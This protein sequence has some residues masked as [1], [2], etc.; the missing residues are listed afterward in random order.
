MAVC[1]P[2]GI[3]HLISSQRK[4]GKAG[5]EY[6]VMDLGL[7]DRP[8]E[9]FARD[10]VSWKPDVVCFSVLSK[11]AGEMGRLASFVKETRGETI[12][13]AGGPHATACSDDV[14][15]ESAVDYCVIGEGERTFAELMDSIAGHGNPEDVRGIVHRSKGA[16]LRT[17]ARSFIEDLD[18]LPGP[19]WEMI[20]LKR[21]SGKQSMNVVSAARVY[22]P[23]MTSR[24]C[25]YECIYCHGMFG[26]KH[27]VFSVERIIGE[28]RELNE[29]FGVGEF[30]VL[31]DAFNLD[32]ERSKRIFREI[33]ASGIKVK[34]SFPNGIRGD[35]VDE[36]MID[37]M[38]R[39]GTYMVTFGVES[40]SG[41]IQQMIRKN[42]DLDKVQKAISM[43]DSEGMLVRGFFM[44]GF[45]GE[46]VD[47]INKTIGFALKS[48]LT[49]AAISSVVPF[50][51]TALG[52]MADDVPCAEEALQDEMHYLS[53]RPFYTRAYG[54]DIRAIQR[55]A[56]MKFYLRPGIILK[57]LRRIPRRLRYAREVYRVLN[58]PAAGGV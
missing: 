35:R 46:T 47:E 57:L 44:I 54:V 10:V 43:A 18:S 50:K 41:R 33:I 19:A 34:L 40:A 45:P 30:A 27:R 55:R 29:R 32:M 37:L 12:V 2:L 25:P 49:M 1:P 20:D 11:E 5:V 26:R 42:L 3:L 53:E 28:I 7:E 14:M 4:W 36:E 13:I 24:A 52:K 17:P 15:K 8:A 21:Y 39:A 9:T 31:D 16:V 48:N 23:I 6:R 51:G 56:Y 38:K 22:A 58:A